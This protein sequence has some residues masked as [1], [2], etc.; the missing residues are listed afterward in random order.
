VR[1]AP[2]PLLDLFD[3][4]MEDGRHDDDVMKNAVEPRLL[5]EVLVVVL[6]GS[7]LREK[8]IEEGTEEGERVEFEHQRV[9]RVEVVW[10]VVVLC[11]V[12]SQPFTDAADEGG[13]TERVEVGRRD[14]Q[15]FMRS[16]AHGRQEMLEVGQLR[17]ESSA[18][19]GNGRKGKNGG[20]KRTNE[21]STSRQFASFLEVGSQT[22]GARPPSRAVGAGLRFVDLVL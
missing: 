12:A 17:H 8:S 16:C 3:E 13:L 11:A 20:E 14:L 7:Q 19:R 9:G 1:V 18:R 6:R 15:R 2:R 4:P 10:V 21:N 22:L 5:A